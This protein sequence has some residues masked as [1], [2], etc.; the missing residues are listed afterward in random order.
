MVRA[1][2]VVK[3]DRV[4]V[5]AEQGRTDA[6]IAEIGQRLEDL[7]PQAG[8]AK[9]DAEAGALAGRLRLL[10]VKRQ[11]L[12][13][14]DAELEAEQQEAAAVALHEQRIAELRNL[15]NVTAT[16]NTQR[17]SIGRLA[18]ELAE[19]LKAEDALFESLLKRRPPVRRVDQRA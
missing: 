4:G 7:A 18:R 3:K 11:Q 10:E 8:Q 12:I 9:A 2:T 15:K 1:L 17:A 13:K 5:E 16:L 14:R 6:Q 19:L